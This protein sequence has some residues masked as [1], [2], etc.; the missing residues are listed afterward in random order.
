MN[1]LRNK[2]TPNISTDDYSGVWRNYRIRCIVTDDTI[3]SQSGQ[4][5]PFINALLHPLHVFV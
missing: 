3:A 4:W 1:F 2:T 5:T